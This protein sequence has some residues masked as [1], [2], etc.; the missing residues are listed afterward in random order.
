[1]VKSGMSCDRISTKEECEG[2]ARALGATDTTAVT[3]SHTSDPPYCFLEGDGT[4]AGTQ[5]WFNTLTSSTDSCSNDDMCICKTSGSRHIT[6][7]TLKKRV[8]ERGEREKEIGRG[9]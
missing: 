7:F 1:M 6:C 3:G 4:L 9:R 5:L 8:R 2:A